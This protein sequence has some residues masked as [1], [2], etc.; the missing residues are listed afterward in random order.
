LQ[1]TALVY[2]I[3]VNV[4]KIR[5]IAAILFSPMSTQM[6]EQVIW[7]PQPGLQTALLQYPVFEVFFGGARGGGTGLPVDTPVLTPFGWRSIGSLTA[8][9]KVCATDGSVTEVIGVYHRGKQ[10]IYR[11]TWS[12]GVDTACDA[13]H[14]WLAWLSNKSRKIGNQR[15]SGEASAKKWTT[16]QIA[17]HYKKQTIIKRRIAIPVISAPAAF[18]VSNQN[19]GRYIQI[20]RTLHPYVLGVL[21]GDGS[22]SGD[23]AKFTSGDPE[24]AARIGQVLNC[25]VVEYKSYES[26]CREYRIPSDYVVADL[27]MLGVMGKRASEK[28]IPRI[29]LLGSVSERW[30]LLRG[31]MDTDGWAEADGDCYFCSVSEAL[32][33]DVREL[34]RSLGAVIST[35]EKA[36][37]YIKDGERVSG[38]P[39]Y[40]LRIKM[41]QP[42]RMF[43]LARKQAVCAGKMPQS[44]AIWLDAIESNGDRETVCIHVAHPN[45]LFI[46]DGYR[47]THNSDRML[48]D[49]ASHADL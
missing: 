31:L 33:R 34:A 37:F 42:E 41:R 25:K 36:P 14:I 27:K 9:S 43:H 38:Q 5:Y 13:D 16:R 15:T 29:Y 20:S 3:F 1:L 7:E 39:A 47:V 28:S 46:I 48:G 8:G 26:N 35:R 18:N 45:S 2:S 30:E 23:S 24:I 21:L 6:P 49:F 12:D 44:M 40:T 22:I 19:Q 10:P 11:L 32:V 4:L 17:D